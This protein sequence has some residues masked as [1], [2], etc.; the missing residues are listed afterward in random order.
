MSCSVPSKE[1]RRLFKRRVVHYITYCCYS[2]E[3][4][5]TSSFPST[6]IV[7]APIVIQA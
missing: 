7:R 6:V 2:P 4:S 3:S 5:V 1:E